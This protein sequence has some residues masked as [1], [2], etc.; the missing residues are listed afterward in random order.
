MVE[1]SQENIYQMNKDDFINNHY[2]YNNDYIQFFANHEENK[3]KYALYLTLTLLNDFDDYDI[4]KCKKINL[5]K[6]Q[7]NSIIDLI[8]NVNDD[9]FGSL[10][11]INFYK[12]LNIDQLQY[13]EKN[14]KFTE[15]N[16]LQPS[17]FN[18]D[19][20]NEIFNLNFIIDMYDSKY[21]ENYYHDNEQQN[22]NDILEPKTK[23]DYIEKTYLNE[24]FYKDNVENMKT[25]MR[26]AF[27]KMSIH[28][29]FCHNDELAIN[30]NQ[31]FKFIFILSAHINWQEKFKWFLL[32]LYRDQLDFIGI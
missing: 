22:P 13:L 26:S 15:L 14:I 3:N 6:P 16:Q 27:T 2:I 17:R 30:S 18:M 10:Y 31:I 8:L 25:Y 5:S 20:Q 21:S 32:Y 23:L 12:S 11:L 19:L 1:L 29:I 7:L 9:H 24:P 28:N 4:N